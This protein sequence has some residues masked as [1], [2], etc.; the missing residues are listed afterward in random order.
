MV[1]GIDGSGKDTV[2]NAWKDHLAAQGN[3][4]FDV[5]DYWK[6]N[7]TYPDF[8][9]L[10]SYDFIFTAEP[11][12]VGIGKVIR[13]ELTRKGTHYSELAIAHAFSLDRLVH[14]EKII[15]PALADGKCVIQVRGVSTSL[16]YQA[17]SG[18]LS[19][20]T[21]AALPGN[22]VALEHRPDYL[23]LMDVSSDAIISRL[24]GRSDK[25]DNSIFERQ[26]FL[27][28]VTT[29]FNS[30]QFQGLFTNRGTVI[31]KLPAH[32]DLATMKDKSLHLLTLLLTSY[33][34]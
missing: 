8:S 16:C 18:T 26:D 15:I 13:E 28:K 25:N 9:E 1:D 12:Y 32:E 3:A 20:N 6:K 30:P 31:E 7:G 34:H 19:L 14:Y 27:E 23:V 22:A 29:F 2:A 5:R 24:S 11:T 17:V 4:L 21:L 10:K 33:A